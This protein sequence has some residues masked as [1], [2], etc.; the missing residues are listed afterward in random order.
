MNCRQCEQA[1]AA[2]FEGCLDANASGL[3]AAHLATCPACRHA[4]E[5][6]RRL[7][8]RL[9]GGAMTPETTEHSMA[10]AVAD[11]IIREQALRLRRIEMMHGRIARVAAA[12][13]LLVAI[14]GL[15]ATLLTRFGGKANA[16][17]LKSASRALERAGTAT[18]KT[19]YYMRFLG[20]FGKESKWVR[21]KNNDQ[22]YYFKSPGLYR[23]EDL[24]ESGKVLFVAIE[25]VPSHALLELNPGE[26]VATLR[27]LAEPSYS[28]SG[29]FATFLGAMKQENLQ[30]LGDK[31]VEG[32]AAD[33]YRFKFFSEGINQNW[34]YE[35]WVD[36]KSQQ[37]VTGQVPGGDIFD[38]SDVLPDKL[39]DPSLQAIEVG[40][41]TFRLAT[42][43]GIGNSS[44]LVHEVAIDRPLDD[45]LFSLRPP[46]GYT[47][48]AVD[49]VDVDEEDVVEFLGALARYFDG[50]FPDRATDFFHGPEYQRFERIERDVLAKRGGTEAQ[51]AFVEAMHKWWRAG[52]PGPGPLHMFITK[53]VEAGSW[54]YLGDG[55]KLGDKERIVCWYRPK[56]SNV[57]HIIFGDL[58]VKEVA[59]EDLP[60]PATR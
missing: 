10:D 47:T 23:R 17:D 16:D 36:S 55:V 1:F 19:S 58:S 31:V 33:G 7:V 21:V 8:T 50:V 48:K 59:P 11:R 24:D 56:G 37:L 53:E 34:S 2:A 28:P 54:K 57:Y 14:G 25:D 5:E 43:L 22:R 45:D 41:A 44:H 42:D 26:K 38:L 13:V 27:Y 6:T 51:V 29:P 60:L 40:G 35:F 12:A 20:Q 4:F 46:E 3:L 49:G 39:W 9:A 30:A 18:W 15:S 32:K 52:L